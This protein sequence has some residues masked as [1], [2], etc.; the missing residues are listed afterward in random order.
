MKDFTYQETLALADQIE[1]ENPKELVKRDRLSN[2]HAL[3]LRTKQH[4]KKSKIPRYG[5]HLWRDQNILSINATKK[6]LSRALLFFDSLIK[7]ANARGHDIIIRNGKTI[8][9]IRKIELEIYLRETKRV[10]D[11]KI[12][13]VYE[14]RKLETTGTLSLAFYHLYMQ[15]EWYDAKSVKLEDK[16]AV[17]MAYLELKADSEIKMQERLELN[18]KIR[19]REEE[20]RKYQ[21]ELICQEQEKFDDLINKAERWF[22]YNKLTDYIDE[23]KTEGLKSKDWILWANQKAEWLDPRTDTKD[24]ILGSYKL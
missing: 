13:K 2:P 20:L 18:R 17:I 16:L 21:G 8:I 7:L 15:K 22:K 14:S 9:I 6:C 23:L 10:V 12:K 24:E 19:E 1:Q 5:Y 11:D 3:V 4:F